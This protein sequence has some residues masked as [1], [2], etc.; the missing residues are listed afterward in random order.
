MEVVRNPD[1]SSSVLFTSWEPPREDQ[2]GR[3]EV[4]RWAEETFLRQKADRLDVRRRASESTDPLERARCRE[5]VTETAPP[6]LEE[7]LQFS[8]RVRRKREVDHPSTL[9]S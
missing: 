2:A 3:A 4:H 1:G 6:S 7:C 9:L 8:R 5:A